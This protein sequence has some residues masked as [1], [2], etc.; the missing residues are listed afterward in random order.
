M[1]LEA[2]SALSVEMKGGHQENQNFLKRDSINLYVF[3]EV[4]LLN[5]S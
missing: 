1:V 4:T 5:Q 3:K 2:S